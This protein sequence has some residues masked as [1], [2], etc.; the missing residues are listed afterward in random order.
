MNTIFTLLINAGG[1]VIRDGIDQSTGRLAQLPYLAP[2]NP[3]PP[4]L[5]TT[6]GDD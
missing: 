2:A 3:D 5:S 6:D 4:E 1:P